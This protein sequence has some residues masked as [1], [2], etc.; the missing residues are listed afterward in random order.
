MR[1]PTLV[2][3]TRNCDKSFISVYPSPELD[4]CSALIDAFF[5]AKAVR[6]DR[7]TFK[8]NRL[9]YHPSTEY[10]QFVVRVKRIN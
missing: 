7:L 9:V 4:H 8:H 6:R 10:Q 1:N 3:S 2:F 5:K